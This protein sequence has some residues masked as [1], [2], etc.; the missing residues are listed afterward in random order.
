V[1]LVFVYG[2]LMKGEPN[3][4]LLSASTFMCQ[5]F[6]ATGFTMIDLGAFPA[7]LAGGTS[8]ITGELYEVTKE[9]LAQLDRLE[10]H[11]HFYERTP[12]RLIG[13]RTVDAYVLKHDD[14]RSRGVIESGSWREHLAAEQR[15][16]ADGVDDDDARAP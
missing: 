5:A 15:W 11:P 8:T 12:I 7:I 2:T 16:V 4:R 14:G 10:G 6:T 3:H 13:G 9:T 1:N